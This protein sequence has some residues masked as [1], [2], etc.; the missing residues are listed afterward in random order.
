MNRILRYKLYSLLLIMVVVNFICDLLLFRDFAGA[1]IDFSIDKL[2]ETPI[3]MI[4]YGSLIGVLALSMLLT[5][6]YGWIKNKV[7]SFWIVLPYFLFVLGCVLFH[8]M[9][10]F[11]GVALHNNNL[12]LFSKIESF[13]EILGPLVFLSGF[14]LT[15]TLAIN[16]YRSIIFFPWWAFL[17]FPLFS[18]IFFGVI[19]NRVIYIPEPVGGYYAVLSGTI[20]IFVF[21]ISKTSFHSK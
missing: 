6:V 1:N 12:I 20:P 13:I 8:G 18:M 3:E 14:I 15:V 19:L 7:L 2:K 10:Y 5:P 21:N 16:R 9:F 17:L 11:L 4:K